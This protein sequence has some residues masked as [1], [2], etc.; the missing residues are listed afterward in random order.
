[1]TLIV[2]HCG[3]RLPTRAAEPDVERY[4]PSAGVVN[5]MAVSANGRLLVTGSGSSAAMLWEPARGIQK[6]A[7]AGH[8]DLA[9][10]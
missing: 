1:L 8:S 3:G 2:L 6:R 10:V 7:L 9:A 4:L 5:R